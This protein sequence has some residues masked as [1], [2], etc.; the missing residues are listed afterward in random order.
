[1]RY[2]LPS[3]SPL[4]SNGKVAG[5]KARDRLVAGHG[6]AGHG[7]DAQGIGQRARRMELQSV[8]EKVQADALQPFFLGGGVHSSPFFE[9]NRRGVVEPNPTRP[10]FKR[11]RGGPRRLSVEVPPRFSEPSKSRSRPC[12]GGSGLRPCGCAPPARSCACGPLRAFPRA[13]RSRRACS[14]SRRPPAS[15]LPRPCPRSRAP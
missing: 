9:R 4:V 11:Q 3:P 10:I 15:C 7:L 6:D 1:M 2:S 8:G 12:A 14:S 5:E 13:R